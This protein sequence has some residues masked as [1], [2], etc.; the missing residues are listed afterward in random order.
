[1]TTPQKYEY[2]HCAAID[3]RV[4]ETQHAELNRDRMQQPK[5]TST[6]LGEAGWELV[7][8]DDGWAYFKRPAVAEVAPDWRCRCGRLNDL[9]SGTCW[10]C[11]TLRP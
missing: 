2:H 10:S 5:R 11:S 9:S 6:I 3:L 4:T 8:V 7:S 1:M